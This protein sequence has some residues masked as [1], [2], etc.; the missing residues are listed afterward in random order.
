MGSVLGLVLNWILIRR[1]A[2]VGAAYAL[3]ITELY[4]TGAMYGYLR[5]KGIEI[6]K[7]AHLREAVAFTKT[8]WQTLTN[9]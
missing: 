8:R 2:H 7:L 4:I 3:V 1:Y 5:W 6:I 9:R